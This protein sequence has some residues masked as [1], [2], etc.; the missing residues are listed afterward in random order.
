MRMS[1]LPFLLSNVSIRE[2]QLVVPSG[3]AGHSVG[4]FRAVA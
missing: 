3:P 2:S 1:V 4:V